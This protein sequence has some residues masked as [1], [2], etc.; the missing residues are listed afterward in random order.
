MEASHL[1]APIATERSPRRL[2]QVLQITWW[3]ALGVLALLCGLLVARRVAGQLRQPLGGAALIVVGLW[4]IGAIWALR[5]AWPFDVDRRARWAPLVERWLI[6]GGCLILF[7]LSISLPGSPRA[8][9]GCFWALLSASELV[10]WLPQGP[11]RIPSLRRLLTWRRAAR[12]LTLPAALQ[13]LN[14][15]SA[16]LVELSEDEDEDEGRAPLA[17]EITQQVTRLRSGETGETVLGLIRVSFRPGERSQNIHLAFCPPMDGTPLLVAHQ[18]AGPPVTIRTA[19]VESYG[20]RLEL[21][22]SAK[23]DQV[24]DVVIRFEAVWQEGRGSRVEG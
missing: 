19:Q 23:S 16:S 21:K 17:D 10:G 12:P 6:P 18:L 15:G 11:R 13:E 9:L 7:G 5:A 20:A 8:A 2:E 22:R 14:H 1:G 24:E 3:T 4:A